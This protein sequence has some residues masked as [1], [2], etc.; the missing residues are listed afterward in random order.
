MKALKIGILIVV[1]LVVIGALVARGYRDFYS[2]K[3]AES[4]DVNSPELDTRVLIVT[5]GSSFKNALVSRITEELG[6]KS[7][8]VNVI[9][10]S[11]LPEINEDD[12]HAL[13]LI[14]ACQSDEMPAEV[15]AYLASTC[16]SDRLTLLVTSGFGKWQPEGVR[17]DSIS[18]ASK[19]SQV[20]PLAT[21]ILTRVERILR[22]AL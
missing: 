5:Q 4:F 21:E 13:V 17:L 2:Q 15:N 14:T 18:S 11:A 8:Y 6:K 16:A 10:V 20:E 1:G 7:I 22:T 12:W 9:D 3:V 19:K